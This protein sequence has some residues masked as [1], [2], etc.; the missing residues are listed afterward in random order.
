MRTKNHIIIGLLA[1]LTFSGCNVREKQEKEADIQLKRVEELINSNSFNA[2]KG[3]IDSLNLQFPHLINKRRIAQALKDTIIRRESARTLTYCNGI[4]PIK[5]HEADSILKN[6][7]FEKDPKYQQ[8]GNYIYKTQ[9]TEDNAF[10][11]YLKCYTDE[12][13]DIY[14]IS[15]YCGTK[16]EH[17]SVLVSANDLFAQTDTIQTTEAANHTYNDGETRREAITFKNNQDKGVAAFIS[18]YSNSIIK[19]KL[20]GKN[21]ASYTLAESDKKAI[22]ETYNLWVVK[23]DIAQLKTEIQK[24]ETRILKILENSKQ[25]N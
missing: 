21:S 1:M 7:R 6:F 23:K 17:T 3:L 2:A 20:I 13:C 16:I 15:N 10:R 11:N 24:A 12:N 9:R 4:L 14:L 22:I 18:Q 8:Y 5:I 19:V 25:K